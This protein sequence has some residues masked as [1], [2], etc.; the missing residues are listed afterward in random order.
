MIMFAVGSVSQYIGQGNGQLH[1]S[2]DSCLTVSQCI[3]QQ[4]IKC[5]LNFG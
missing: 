4:S 5:C 3:S 1:M 2:V